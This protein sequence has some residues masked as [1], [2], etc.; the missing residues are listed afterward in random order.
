MLEDL[1]HNFTKS[2][3]ASGISI[4][5]RQ[6]QCPLGSWVVAKAPCRIDIFGGW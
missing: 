1:G 2:C 5:S 4:Q 3:V 6:Y